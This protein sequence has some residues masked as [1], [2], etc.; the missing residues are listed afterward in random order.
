MSAASLPCKFIVTTSSAAGQGKVPV[1]IA[2]ATLPAKVRTAG[3]WRA[4]A[5]EFAPFGPMLSFN[6][7]DE[8]HPTWS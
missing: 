8:L 1:K 5:E 7:L 3:K 6:P 4:C 2:L